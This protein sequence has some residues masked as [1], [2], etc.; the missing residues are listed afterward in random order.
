M[1]HG[2]MFLYVEMYGINKAWT[3]GFVH[4]RYG[5]NPQF[6]GN[7]PRI[8]ALIV[9]AL[10]YA[11][12]VM[13][14]VLFFASKRLEP[15]IM[16]QKMWNASNDTLAV[17]DVLCDFVF[18]CLI[19]LKRWREKVVLNFGESKECWAHVGAFLIM[20]LLH[21]WHLVLTNGQQ[22]HKRII[23]DT[24]GTDTLP[25]MCVLMFLLFNVLFPQEI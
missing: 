5:P 21:V 9:L 19:S 10:G 20:V 3:C 17:F 24:Y 7:I 13:P 11:K 8:G 22:L 6:T 2:E 1:I 4:L 16:P 18:C 15:Y 23:N 25:K 12:F 14:A